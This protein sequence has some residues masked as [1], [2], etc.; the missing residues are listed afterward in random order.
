[1]KM[2]YACYREMFDGCTELET[3]P[4]LPATTLAPYC[5]RYMFNSCKKLRDVQKVL[6]AMILADHCYSWM[7]AGCDE[8]EKAPE[9]P[10]SDL[11]YGC[12]QHMFSYSKK[13]R[14]VKCMVNNSINSSQYGTAYATGYWLEGAGE[15]VTGEK[16]FVKKKGVEWERNGSGIPPGWT[17]VEEE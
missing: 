11:V 13:L 4:N 15:L 9:L 14:Y 1:M 6:P 5:Y 3:A 17:I 8:L 12:Y 7:F 10:A 2:E 16:I